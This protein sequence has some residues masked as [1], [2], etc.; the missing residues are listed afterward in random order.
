MNWF[1][2]IY[3]GNKSIPLTLSHPK[4][5]A[6]QLAGKDKGNSHSCENRNLIFYPKS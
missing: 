4:G 3:S 5:W 6:T 1:F 2:G